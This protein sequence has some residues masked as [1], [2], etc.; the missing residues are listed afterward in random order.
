MEGIYTSKY[1]G[2]GLFFFVPLISLQLKL[3]ERRAKRRGDLD[4]FR[5]N[6]IPLSKT[7]LFGEHLIVKAV[8]R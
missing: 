3:K 8:K 7:M 5:I 2:P 1:E 6:K 4:F